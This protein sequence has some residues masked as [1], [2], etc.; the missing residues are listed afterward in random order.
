MKILVTSQ[1]IDK[2]IRQTFADLSMRPGFEIWIAGEGES[3]RDHGGR[4]QGIDMPPIKSKVS[5]G[6]IRALRRIMKDLDID[7]VFCHS[8]SGLSCS[9]IASAGLKTKVVGYRGTQAKVRRFDP[10][11]RLALLNP[12][13]SHIV[14]AGDDIAEYLSR[15][16][17]REKL[18]SK[19]KPYD[20]DWVADAVANPEPWGERAAGEFRIAYIGMTAGRPFKGLMTLIDA[21][22]R[23]KDSGVRLTVVGEADPAE[24]AAAGDNVTFAGFR[25]DAVRFIPEADVLVLPSHRDASPRVVREAQACGVPCIVSDIPGTRELILPGKTGLLFPPGD[26]DALVKAISEMKDNPERVAEMG[27][28]AREHIREH[29]SPKEYTDYFERLFKSLK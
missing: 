12:A 18:S 14:C 7:A 24:I 16:I 19:R 6:A 8:T 17:P 29:F 10:T 20:V 15:W 28:A 22:N 1:A 13:V 11:Y 21:V 2:V 27:I 26:T 5:L 9:L 23:M 3:A 4:V 25:T